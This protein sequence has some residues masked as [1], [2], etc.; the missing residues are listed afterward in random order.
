[1]R[2]LRGQ[3]TLSVDVNEGQMS[4]DAIDTSEKWTLAILIYIDTGSV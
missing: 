2:Q 4:V 1:M 3:Y